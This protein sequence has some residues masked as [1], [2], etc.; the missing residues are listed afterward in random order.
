MAA[1]RRIMVA[2][3]V[4]SAFI[5]PPAVAQ[6]GSSVSLTHTV[7]VTVPPRVKVQVGGNTVLTQTRLMA[8]SRSTEG[9]NISVDATRSWVLSVGTAGGSS[10]LE[11]SNDPARGF[12]SIGEGS[13][14]VASGVIS[15]AQ[16][17]A[18]LFFRRAGAG[19]SEHYGDEVSDAVVLTVVA[20]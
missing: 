4:G 18:M 12:R 19:S 14:P 15:Q 9:L 7:T 11:W 10:Q 20:P 2:L 5:A 17:A 13:A 3:A 1:T 8:P 6:T 16:A